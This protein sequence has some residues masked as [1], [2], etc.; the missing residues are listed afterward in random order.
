MCIRDSLPLHND[1]LIRGFWDFSRFAT[2]TVWYSAAHGILW[3]FSFSL[4]QILETV[5]RVNLFWHQCELILFFRWIISITEFFEA[6]TDRLGWAPEIESIVRYASFWFMYLKPCLRYASL[7]EPG[8]LPLDY[9]FTNNSSTKHFSPIL[10]LSR[11]KP[12]QPTSSEVRT[13]WFLTR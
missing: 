11:T 2:I 10:G 5:I 4:V 7:G 6:F 8:L 3:A 13:S 1:S 12:S 9:S